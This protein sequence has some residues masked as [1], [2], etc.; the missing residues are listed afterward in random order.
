[1]SNMK[2]KTRIIALAFLACFLVVSLLSSAFIFT[3]AEHEHDHNGFDGGC[4]T[5]AQLQ[6]AE[7]ILKQLSTAFAGVLF[8]VAGLFAA[9]GTLKVIAGYASLSTPVTLKIRM[10]N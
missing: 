1:M 6:N 9:I 2:S 8:A 7:N 5:C 4:A 3:H 10:N